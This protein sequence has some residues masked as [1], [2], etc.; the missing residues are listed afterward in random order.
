MSNK[1]EFIGQPEID[2][3]E[4]LWRQGLPRCD[5]ADAV[6]LRTRQLESLKHKGMID[7]PPRQGKNGGCQGRPLSPSEIKRACAEVQQ[8]WT[9]E[10]EQ[11]RRSGSGTVT[12][13]SGLRSQGERYGKLHYETS[14]LHPLKGR[15]T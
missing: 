7:V 4:A 11:L 12:T 15:T 3:I 14:K 8:S 2:T 10:E 5:I 6:G 1:L 13:E 9:P